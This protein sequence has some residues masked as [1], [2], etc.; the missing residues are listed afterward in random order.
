MNK[1]HFFLIVAAVATAIVALEACGGAAQTSAPEPTKV[2]PTVAASA[3]EAPAAA[4]VAK[5]SNAGGTGDAVNLTGDAASGK[6][7]YAANCQACHGDQGKGGVKNDGSDDG[8]VP[9]LNPIDST[10]IDKDVKTYITNLDLFLEHGSTP[11]GDKPT[12]V[13]PAFG[14]EK[15]L[16]PQEIADVIAYLM[17]LNPAQ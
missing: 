4:E 17:S 5:P 10:L 2:P 16:K 11:E 12:L 9:P 7:L 6:T 3:T 1:R 15:K 8:E 14:D 13:M